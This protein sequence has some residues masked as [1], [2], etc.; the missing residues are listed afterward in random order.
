MKLDIIKLCFELEIE[1]SEFTLINKLY[2][3]TGKDAYFFIRSLLNKFSGTSS[4]SLLVSAMGNTGYT[5]AL[6]D[7]YAFLEKDP[8]ISYMAATAI[9]N[10][11]SSGDFDKYH[12]IFS[13]TTISPQ[14]KQIMIMHIGELSKKK[15]IPY[16][17]IEDLENNLFDE[18]DNLRYLSLIALADIGHKKSLSAILKVFYNKEMEPFQQDMDNT[19]LTLFSGK[20]K[21]IRELQAYLSIAKRSIRVI[22]QFSTPDK[23]T[24]QRARVDL[25]ERVI[26]RL[27]SIP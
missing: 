16:D 9:K 2:Q 5:E 6:S 25:I 24:E 12:H 22:H 7:F 19:L 27:H 13:Q 8:L 14:I 4:Q 20:D 26:D 1:N 11:D 18:N 15:N 23:L 3:Y 17:I 21:L 10:L